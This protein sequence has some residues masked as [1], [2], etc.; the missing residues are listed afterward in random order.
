MTNISSKALTKEE[1][2]EFARELIRSGWNQ[3]AAYQRIRP[4]ASY[5]TARNM[6]NYVANRP[7]IISAIR[8]VLEENK[9]GMNDIASMLHQSIT[10]GLGKKSTNRDAIAGLKLAVD[11]HLGHESN[12]LDGVQRQDLEEQSVDDLIERLDKMK[13]D[14]MATRKVKAVDGEI[15]GK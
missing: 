15:V 12:E 7:G 2:E 1:K 10:S 5:N 13:H 4:D 9:L 14:L 3:T 11:M 6:G 8:T